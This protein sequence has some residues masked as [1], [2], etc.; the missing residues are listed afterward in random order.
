I[1]PNAV[2]EHAIRNA[3]HTLSQAIGRTMARTSL[4]IVLSII[5]F[6]AAAQL[7]DRTQS[8]TRERHC[9]YGRMVVRHP[10]EG[11]IE[12][13]FP[14]LLELQADGPLR[15]WRVCQP[16]FRPSRHKDPH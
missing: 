11:G 6:P 9:Y 2:Q 1:P 7:I 3:L 8:P 5:A 12:I 16:L 15:V 14:D 10:P 4:L 13:S